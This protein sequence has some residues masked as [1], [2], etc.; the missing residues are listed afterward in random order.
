MLRTITL[1]LVMLVSVLAML[2]FANSTAHGIRQSVSAGQQRRYRRHS[3]AWWRRYRARL[4]VRRE[5]A[6]AAHRNG[7]LGPSL[8]LRA[9]MNDP[10]LSAQVSPASNTAT[11]ANSA[12][13]KF[14][15][16]KST[17]VPGQLSLSV[18]ALS[19]PNPAYVSAREQGRMLAGLNVADLRRIVIDKMLVSG[20][21]VTNDY[22]REVSGERVYVVTAQTP[23]D[24]KTPEKSWSFYFTEANGRVYNLTT[25]TSPEYSDKMA[26]EA[27]KFI[28]SLRSRGAV[29]PAVR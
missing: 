10:M 19:R 25:N 14:A 22:V 11:T 8:S 29:Q 20:G 4:R 7:L 1:S 3:R 24:G 5:A 18:V 13:L 6:L 27:Q 23:A 17:S 9:R 26:L 28:E 16:P 12:D 15:A 2:P 21:W